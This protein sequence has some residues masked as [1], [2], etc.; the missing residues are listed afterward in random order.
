MRWKIAHVV[1]VPCFMQ[2]GTKQKHFFLL[3][4]CWTMMRKPGR[5]IVKETFALKGLERSGALDE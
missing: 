3:K 1:I 5:V 4:R 2:A